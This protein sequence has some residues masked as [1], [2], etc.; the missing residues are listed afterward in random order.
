VVVLI[1]RINTKGWELLPSEEKSLIDSC[2]E[3]EVMIEL[4][5][6]YPTMLPFDYIKQ[7]RVKLIQGWDLHGIRNTR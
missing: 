5:N 7:K 3:N 4:N 6:K 1:V 2:K